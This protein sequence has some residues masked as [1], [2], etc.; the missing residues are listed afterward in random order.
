LW[1]RG[2]GW[3]QWATAAVG[4]VL[5]VGLAGLLIPRPVDGQAGDGPSETV[6]AVIQGGVPS[7]GI[8]V[9]DER[10]AV[11]ERHIRQTILLAE[12]VATGVAPQRDVVIWPETAV[13][14]DPYR[15]PEIADAI[16]AAAGVVGAPIVIG[17][18]ID[19]PGDASMIA[20]AGIVWDPVSGP[21][22]A[23][24]KRHP[25]PFG[26]FIP[27]RSLIAP[28]VGRLDRIPRDMRAGDEPGVLR[29]GD[30][31]LG[32]VICFEVAYDEVVRDAVTA[33]GRVIVVQTN[34]ATFAG[35]GQPEQQVAMSRLRAIEHG[36]AVLVAAT[37]GIS[38][39]IGP[40]G[41]V[42]AEIPEGESGYLI[43]TV[44]LRDSLTL[45]DRLG[46]APEWIVALLG[47]AAMLWAAVRRRDGARVGHDR[48][49]GVADDTAATA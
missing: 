13:D 36:R 7:T 19:A 25:V 45:A 5:V 38:A 20:N 33:G 34:N 12:D 24:L 35:L 39:I 40:D 31:V 23:Y 1:L 47:A 3:R 44:V 14:I 22:D 30:V 8:S 4:G 15:T 26:E 48:L 42:V 37:T 11:L 21:G 16:T 17:A 18:I 10:R 28:L 46:S 41:S 9:N 32:D 2:P 6:A 27:F 49:R 29:A 43:D